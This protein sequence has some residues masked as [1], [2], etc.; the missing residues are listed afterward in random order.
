MSVDV[1]VRRPRLKAPIHKREKR[2]PFFSLPTRLPLD[3]GGRE[4]FVNSIRKKS[5]LMGHSFLKLLFTGSH[6]SEMS[7]SVLQ[8]KSF[9]AMYQVGA[10]KH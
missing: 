3:V 8:R 10:L 5:V 2:F 9:F 7:S 1:V 4:R 6:E